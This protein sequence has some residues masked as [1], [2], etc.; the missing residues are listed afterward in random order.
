MSNEE[1]IRNA[2][3]LAKKHESEKVFT[4]GVDYHKAFT[5][6]ANH[7]EEQSFLV[8]KL[9]E[10]IDHL[11][12]E[13]N[14]AIALHKVCK[15][16]L[17]AK[18]KGSPVIHDLD[19]DTFSCA[20]CGL[21]I[22]NKAYDYCPDCRC[23]LCGIEEVHSDQKETKTAL[24]SLVDV[25]ANIE[26]MLDTIGGMEGRLSALEKTT[27]SE[28]KCDNCEHAY[29]HFDKEPCL[30]CKDKDKWE[31]NEA[32]DVCQAETDSTLSKYDSCENNAFCDPLGCSDAMPCG[33]YH[34]ISEK[35]QE[36]NK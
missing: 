29:T 13:C 26:N 2:R 9:N 12:T 32:V 27:M 7:I 17:S 36:A 18:T 15:S 16:E 22:T 35:N 28:K 1:I 4:F 34:P 20:N 24:I 23:L 30:S 25:L 8:E 3:E 21:D 5:D 31:S 6:I 10:R 14:I 33:M 11:K 19:S